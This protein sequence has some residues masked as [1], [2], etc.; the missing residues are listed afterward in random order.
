MHIECRFNKS[1]LLQCYFLAILPAGKWKQLVEDS[2]LATRCTTPCFLEYGFNFYS[3]CSATVCSWSASCLYS[4]LHET[5]IRRK[6]PASYFAKISVLFFAGAPF[7]KRFFQ[8]TSNFPVCTKET[9]EFSSFQEKASL[10]YKHFKF[11]R[12]T[13][14]YKNIGN[15][16]PTM[17]ILIIY[18]EIF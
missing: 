9:I 18:F 3:K 17:T 8:K 5:K 16:W 10:F 14:W 7:L 15:K 12:R 1:S 2:L 6:Q 4:F 11:S 13:K